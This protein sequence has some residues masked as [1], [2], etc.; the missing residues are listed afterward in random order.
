[1]SKVWY[2]KVV[3]KPVRPNMMISAS[4]MT[5]GGVMIGSSESRRIGPFSGRPVRSATRAKARPSRVE[6]RPTTTASASVFQAAPQLPAPVRHSRPQIERSVNLAQ[7][8]AG[9]KLPWLSRTAEMST[10]ITGQNT[11]IRMAP[12]MS[13]M[14]PS[15]KASPRH[16]PWRARPMAASWV[17]ASA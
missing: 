6:S 15:T 16:Q 9:A 10:V 11:K 12:R 5:K 8:S 4:P 3:T 14:A 13:R 1:M 7:N 17:A 2:R